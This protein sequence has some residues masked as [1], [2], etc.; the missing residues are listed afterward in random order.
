MDDTPPEI[1]ISGQPYHQY[2][3]IKRGKRCNY[4]IKNKSRSKR[5]RIKSTELNAD[6]L[7]K[8]LN[9]ST[10]IFGIETIWYIW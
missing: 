3:M 7:G 6:G 9:I 2:L 5:K 1:A 10:L 8:M 4:S